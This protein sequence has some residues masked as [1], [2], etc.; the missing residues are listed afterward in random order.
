MDIVQQESYNINGGNS[1]HRV[2]L[3]KHGIISWVVKFLDVLPA[4]SE[5]S[6]E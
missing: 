2:P 5:N 3:V 4:E 6:T 1:Y